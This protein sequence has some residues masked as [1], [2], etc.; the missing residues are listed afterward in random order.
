[1]AL[2]FQKLKSISEALQQTQKGVE[3]ERGSRTVDYPSA[4]NLVTANVILLMNV[5]VNR[6]FI[7]TPMT[8]SLCR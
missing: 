3:G 6:V 7:Q 1:M 4:C 8:D 2:P 5:F